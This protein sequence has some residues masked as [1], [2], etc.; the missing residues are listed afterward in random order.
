VEKVQTTERRAWPFLP[1][2]V[3]IVVGLSILTALVVAALGVSHLALASER[4]V[5]THLEV[6]SEVF[7]QR[8]QE[9]E[10]PAER[11][12]EL[13]AKTEGLEM[14]LLTRSGEVLASAASRAPSAEARS[15]YLHA[16]SGET[17]SSFGRAFFRSSSVGDASVLVVIAPARE[18]A[19]S[20]SALL[21][22]LLALTVL[23]LLVAAAVAYSVAYDTLRDIVFVTDRIRAMV[24]VSSEPA[25]TAIPARTGDEVGALTLAFNALHARFEMAEAQHRSDLSRA[26]A[27]DENRSQFLATVSHEL[28]TPLNSI[29]GFAE[30]LLKEVDGP[31]PP[32]AREDIEQV[33]D[34]GQNLAKLVSDIVEFSALEGGQLKLNAQS[35]DLTQVAREVVRESQVLARGKPVTL[36]LEGRQAVMIHADAA[37]VRQILSNLVSNALKFTR[38]GEVRV[39]VWSEAGSGCVSVLDTGPGISPEDR[40]LIFQEYKQTELG[41]G[42][43]TGLGLA[44]ARRL[45]ALHG[46]KLRLASEVGQGSEFRVVF[47]RSEQA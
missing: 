41:R 44:I 5:R 11:V 47:R 20:T 29:L 34:S 43:G 9:D 23:L 17:E 38:R 32:S 8:L 25:G 45:V 21:A 36:T 28:R 22:A 10:Y 35:M 40:A 27:Q 26:R 31:L 42:R 19:E 14:L 13:A 16:S 46:A 15:A 33:R 30:V 1:L 24:R 39:K 4:A 18:R 6:A 37:R 3:V 12:L 7:A 2:P